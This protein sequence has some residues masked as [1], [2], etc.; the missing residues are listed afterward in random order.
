MQRLQKE[1]R[2]T[3]QDSPKHLLLRA[4][5]SVNHAASGDSGCEA[6]PDA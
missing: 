4:Y 5:E 1:K 3:V 6:S 2:V